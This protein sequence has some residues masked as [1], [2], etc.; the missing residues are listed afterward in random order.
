M[1]PENAFLLLLFTLTAIV[2]IKEW[3]RPDLAALLLLVVLGLTGFVSADE[4][5]NGFS[6]SA[7]ITIIA[8]F[9]ITDALER[10]GAT[11]VLG[12]SLQRLAA[13]SEGRTTLVVMLA[14]ATLSLFMNTIAAA[15]V[16]LP[17]VIGITR[18]GK[19]RA[20]KLLIP[21]SFGALLGGMATLFTTANILVS[22]ALAEQG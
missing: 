15:A 13:G 11:R 21:L 10:T 3:L 6:R 12:Q 16:L 18:Q 9:I 8:L 4:L 7:V 17:A 20:S 2:L 19:L 14:T 1:T 22:N 5:F